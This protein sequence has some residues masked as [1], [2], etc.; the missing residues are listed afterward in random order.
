MRSE[1]PGKGLGQVLPAH[2]ALGWVLLCL[3]LHSPWGC[4]RAS[5]KPHGD[6]VDAVTPKGPPMSL[7]PPIQPPLPRSPRQGLCPANS[8]VANKF[9]QFYPSNKSYFYS[10]SFQNRNQ[11]H[12]RGLTEPW[13]CRTGCWVGDRDTGDGKP[14]SMLCQRV[15]GHFAKGCPQTQPGGR[16]SPGGRC[17]HLCPG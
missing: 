16:W 5:F 3:F 4:S 10:E 7:C 13:C 8:L 17:P 15:R 2:G 14:R 9:L 6:M 1:P 11:K 12:P